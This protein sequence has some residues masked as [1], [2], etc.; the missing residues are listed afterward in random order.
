ME[1]T[2]KRIE[3]LQKQI[4]PLQETQNIISKEDC[5]L[6]ESIKK[7]KINKQ[8]LLDLFENDNKEYRQKVKNFLSK[9]EFQERPEIIQMNSDEQQDWVFKNLLKILEQ[10]FLLGKDIKEDPLK[11]FAFFES[12]SSNSSSLGMKFSINYSFFTW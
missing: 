9:E 11:Y 8:E 5:F 2:K 3:I 12:F 6:F 10:K 1:T 7:I 4:K